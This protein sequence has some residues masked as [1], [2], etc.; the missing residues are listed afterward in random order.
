MADSS[1]NSDIWR[2]HVTVACVVARGERYLMVE[3][4]VAGR[5]VYNQPAGHL[6]DHESLAQAALRETLEETGWTVELQ[7][8]IGVHQWRSTEHGDA[9]V[10]FSFAA[11]AISHDPNRPLDSDIRRAL[12]LTREE[13]AA[14]GER[15]R[16]P[17]I[18]QSIDLWLGG[19]RLPLETLSHLPEGE[20]S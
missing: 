3:E 19:Q 4:E 2:P 20:P 11:R 14:L 9:V 5:L 8:L 10:R 17:M 18:L 15:L 6:D 12:W 7:H 16:S 1:P 13:I